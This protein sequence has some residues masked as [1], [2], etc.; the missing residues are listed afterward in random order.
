[1]EDIWNFKKLKSVKKRKNNGE[2]E[3]S[4]GSLKNMM[5][6]FKEKGKV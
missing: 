4:L 3:K 5:K 6:E 1:L 2:K